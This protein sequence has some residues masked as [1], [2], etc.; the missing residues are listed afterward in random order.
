MKWNFALRVAAVLVI[1]ISIV[2]VL[3]S[4]SDRKPNHQ[5]AS[6]S[7]NFG[8]ARPV[9][10]A[11]LELGHSGHYFAGHT[12]HSIYL[13]NTH[14]PGAVIA[15][16]HS[17]RDTAHLALTIG[18]DSLAYRAISVKIDSPYFYLADGTMPFIYKGTLQT[19]QASAWITD[20]AFSRA[21]PY[22][23]N[24]V[25]F[26]VIR[27]LKN[28]I[29]RKTEH[30]D[31]ELFPGILEEQG[32][33]IFS[34]DGTFH[35]RRSRGTFVYLYYYRNQYIEIDSTFAHPNRGNTVD[36]VTIAKIVTRK[37]RSENTLTMG[38]PPLHV[39]K[40]SAVSDKHLFVHSNLL[41]KNEDPKVFEATT[42][43]DVYDLDHRR[44]RH[45]FY[46]PA[47]EKKKKVRDFIVLHDTMLIALYDTRLV[48]YHI[49]SLYKEIAQ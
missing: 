1:S 2:G 45:S 16:D 29:A 6:F 20:I 17:L 19:R 39:N 9:E 35:Y 32:D 11:S 46:I 8:D 23:G 30:A 15:V 31:L 25:A 3:Y 4:L 7:R 18:H 28:T 10:V 36:T 48:N 43:V 26:V 5:Y 14:N 38:A 21:I 37:I 33:G 44:Y 12:N 42:V 40:A 24:S 47:I 27:N 41:G 13:G 22:A 34:T 49:E